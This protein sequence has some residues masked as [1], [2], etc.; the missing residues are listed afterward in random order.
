M[1]NMAQEAQIAKEIN[2]GY[3]ILG[4]GGLRSVSVSICGMCLKTY[5]TKGS[6]ARGSAGIH[7][8]KGQGCVTMQK[9]LMWGKNVPD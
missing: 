8:R 7:G 4:G 9:V 2:A 6:V 5:R 3:E 1:A